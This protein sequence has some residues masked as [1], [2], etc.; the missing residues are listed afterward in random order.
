MLTEKLKRM[1]GAFMSD[2]MMVPCSSPGFHALC[3]ALWPSRMSNTS[4]F[5]AWKGC[6]AMYLQ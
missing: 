2:T 1:S 4:C 5:T 3:N 6:S